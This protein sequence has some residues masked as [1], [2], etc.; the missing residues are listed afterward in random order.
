MRPLVRA[1]QDREPAALGAFNVFAPTAYAN[2]KK[3]IVGTR[4]VL[5]W[6]VIEGK[7]SVKARLVVGGL[8]DPASLQGL[9]ATAGCVSIRLSHLQLLCLCVRKN[10]APG[11]GM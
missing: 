4:W 8:Q 6:K 2:F 7:A 11:A 5:T 9:V 1:A 3:T 10:G